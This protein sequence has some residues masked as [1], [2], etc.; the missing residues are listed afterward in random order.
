MRE[1]IDV[2]NQQYTFLHP[3]G[4]VWFDLTEDVKRYENYRIRY[5]LGGD[6]GIHKLINDEYK[7]KKGNNN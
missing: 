6:K 4:S 7:G 3:D 2:I 1:T 5:K